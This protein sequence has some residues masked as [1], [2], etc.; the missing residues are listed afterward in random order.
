MATLS[1]T[2]GDDSWSSDPARFSFQVAA[3]MPWEASQ[4]APLLA[5][6]RAD[7]RM[8]LL[9]RLLPGI[10]PELEQRAAIH[11]RAGQNGKGPQGSTLASHD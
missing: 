6:R 8:A 7:E 10:V 4:A 2:L 9:L 5:M 1:D 3:A 11:H